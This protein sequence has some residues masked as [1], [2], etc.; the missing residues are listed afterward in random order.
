MYYIN[1]DYIYSM[2]IDFKKLVTEWN[3][4]N[5][6]RKISQRSIAREMVNAGI[7]K[8][9]GSAIAMMQYHSSGR[10]KS[11]DYEMLMFLERRFGKTFDTLVER[12][13]I[14]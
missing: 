3:G 2:K 9:T 8:T 11:V 10:A 4:Q 13:F 6:L 12:E 7:F 5:P 1:I 14:H